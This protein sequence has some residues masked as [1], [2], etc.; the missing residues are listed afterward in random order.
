MAVIPK[1]CN[2]LDEPLEFKL[3]VCASVIWWGF[4][5]KSTVLCTEANL[6]KVCH[7]QKYYLIFISHLMIPTDF[8]CDPLDLT[9]NPLDQAETL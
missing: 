4:N 1:Q 6:Q 2:I 8:T 9:L 5:L 7:F 3:E